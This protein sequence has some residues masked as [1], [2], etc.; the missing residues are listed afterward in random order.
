MEYAKAFSTVEILTVA[1]LFLGPLLAVY[2]GRK[3]DDRRLKRERRMDVFRTLMR[4]RRDTLSFDHVS[5]LNLVEVEFQSDRKV[6]DA[7][8]KYLD[9]LCQ[10]PVRTQDEVLS[11]DTPE[12]QRQI[13]NERYFGRIILE[14]QELLIEILRVMAQTLDHEVEVPRIFK[15]GYSPQSWAEIENEQ[16][17]IRKFVVDL[18]YGRRGLPMFPI[19]PPGKTKPPDL[20]KN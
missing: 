20:R 17:I 4:T 19:E 2:I 18:Y 1:A 8:K 7:W 6:I 11:D 12:P 15:S 3:L 13:R 14:R 5:A 16:A 9:S 10:D